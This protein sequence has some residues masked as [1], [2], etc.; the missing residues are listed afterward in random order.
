[1]YAGALATLEDLGLAYACD[2]TR[3]TFA[4]WRA[5]HRAS[6]SG[7]GCPGGCRRRRLRRDQGVGIRVALGD[8]EESWADLLRGH[9]H[10]PV[11]PGGD[12]LIRDRNGNWT[13]ALC[14]V[15]DDQRHGVDL[16]V[17]GEDLVDATAA[18][19]RLGRMLRRSAPP[20]FAHHP[21]VLRPDGSKLSKADGATAVGDLLEAGRSRDSLF[22]E[23]SL[24]VG[25]QPDAR[26]LSFVAA[27]GLVGEILAPD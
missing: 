3:S 26:A 7:P 16:V 12:L 1:M 11:A 13:Y 22:G 6:W 20:L 24:R 15:V 25:L 9:C 5:E 4:S 17:R 14:V 8:G 21:L 2:C 19:I 27:T 10:G 18:Q 23:A